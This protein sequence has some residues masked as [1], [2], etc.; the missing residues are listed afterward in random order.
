M[1]IN[2]A[3]HYLELP[4]NS[5]LRGLGGFHFHVLQTKGIALPLESRHAGGKSFVNFSSLL[6]TGLSCGLSAPFALLLLDFLSE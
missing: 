6:L 4:L 3:F 2:R 5:W 1:Q